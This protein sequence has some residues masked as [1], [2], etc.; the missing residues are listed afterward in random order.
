M[1][2]SLKKV[3]Y[4]AEFS[5]ETPCYTAELY[6]DSKKVATVKND[7]RGGSTDVCFTE[8]LQSELAQKLEEYANNNPVVYNFNGYVCESKGVPRIMDA[9]LDKW[10]EEKGL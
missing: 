8:G 10:L 4:Y 6:M 3:K 7:G 9:L 5:E 1:T 2:L